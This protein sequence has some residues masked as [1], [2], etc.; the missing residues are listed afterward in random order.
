[1]ANFVISTTFPVLSNIGLT[2]AY[3]F[4]ALCALLSLVFVFLRI[5]ETKGKELEDMEELTV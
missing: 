5:P 1:M 4:Y 2:F 3:G